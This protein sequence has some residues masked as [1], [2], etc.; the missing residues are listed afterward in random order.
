MIHTVGVTQVKYCYRMNINSVQIQFVQYAFHL[1]QLQ[2]ED[3]LKMT[4]KIHESHLGGFSTIPSVVLSLVPPN[5]YDVLLRPC[6]QGT[7][8]YQNQEDSN[9]VMRGPFLFGN[10][11]GNSG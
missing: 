8:I 6:S 7:P 5:F 3:A 1:N 11:I 2:T 10:E 4:C 9:W